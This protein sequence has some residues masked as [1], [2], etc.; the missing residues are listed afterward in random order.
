MVYWVSIG[1]E[2]FQTVRKSMRNP[3]SIFPKKAWLLTDNKEKESVASQHNLHTE[4]RGFKKHTTRPINIKPQIT[5]YILQKMK[6]ESDQNDS[7]L[8]AYDFKDHSNHPLLQVA[9]H[10]IIWQFV[11]N[12]VKWW[13]LKTKSFCKKLS[14]LIHVP[15]VFSVH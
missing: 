1:G 14:K 6:H 3:S 5:W 11:I 12:Q 4:G 15:K 13:N 9:S 8:L 7:T 10:Q 2:Q